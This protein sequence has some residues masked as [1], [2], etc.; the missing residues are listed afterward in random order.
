MVI[1]AKEAHGYVTKEIFYI[2]LGTRS[3]LR[4]IFE[5][6]IPL[7]IKAKPQIILILG[8]TKANIKILLIKF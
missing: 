4:K 7:H 5:E 6:L 8:F 3:V 2:A 1:S